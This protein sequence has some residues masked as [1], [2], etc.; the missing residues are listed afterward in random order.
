MFVILQD[1]KA[2]ALSESQTHAMLIT[3]GSSTRATKTGAKT[4]S[5][6]A[7]QI[8]RS[9]NIRIRSVHSSTVQGASVPSGTKR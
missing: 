5:A 2:S 4:N 3:S 9:R 1:N 6:W 8:N 7:Y